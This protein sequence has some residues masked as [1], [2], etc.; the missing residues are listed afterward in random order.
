MS[1]KT[2]LKIMRR[3]VMNL[4]I[5]FSLV[6]KD[7]LIFQMSCVLNYV[8]YL[9]YTVGKDRQIF[10][11]SKKTADRYLLKYLKSA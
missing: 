5:Q 3:T 9:V 8:F 2:P 10:G 6:H 4:S 7:Q 1:R 11:K